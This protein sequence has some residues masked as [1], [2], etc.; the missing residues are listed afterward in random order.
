[1]LTILGKSFKAKSQTWRDKMKLDKIRFAW[2]IA[3]VTKHGATLSSYEIEDIDGMLEF[4]VQSQPAN[5]VACG[6]VD[7]LLR[8]LNKPDGFIPA[9]KAYR[10]LTGAGLKESKEA[11]ERYRSIPNFPQKDVA[12]AEEVK[13][14]PSNATLGDILHSAGRTKAGNNIG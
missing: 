8:Q 11:I 10:V 5:K 12:P 2:L 9:I 1:V 3:F 4:E 14:D 13:I 7:E 6:D